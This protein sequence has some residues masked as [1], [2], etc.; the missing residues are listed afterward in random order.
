[1]GTVDDESRTRTNCSFVREKRNLVVRR[2]NSARSE[3]NLLLPRSR[4]A[5]SETR[6]RKGP[7]GRG[8]S[9]LSSVHRPGQRGSGKSTGGRSLTKFFRRNRSSTHASVRAHT[10]RDDLVEIIFPVSLITSLRQRD[11]IQF[12][13]EPQKLRE[14]ARFETTIAGDL[15]YLELETNRNICS[16]DSSSEVVG[17]RIDHIF[18]YSDVRDQLYQRRRIVGSSNESP[19]S[20]PLLEYRNN[21]TLF[22]SSRRRRK[23]FVVA[24]RELRRLFLRT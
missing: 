9:E 20:V 10:F 23:S 19:R 16:I 18:A 17:R 15:I 8:G 24:T 4:A 6:I 7:R 22:N 11:V 13:D 21:R 14:K 1:M 3:S 5:F 12:R 2:G